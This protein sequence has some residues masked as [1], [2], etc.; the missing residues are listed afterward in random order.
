MKNFFSFLSRFK[1]KKVLCLDGG[2]VRTI[3]AIVFLMKLEAESGKKVSDVFDMFIGNSAGALNAACFAFGGF[4][5]D[6]VKRYWSENYLD[7]I[8]SENKTIHGY[9][10]STKGNVLL[11]YFGITKK[12]IK[13]IADRNPKKNNHFTPGT[14]M[15]IISENKSSKSKKKT[16]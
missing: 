14:K 9:G 2:G 16:K 15:R 13:Y 4:S 1:H 11:Q 6:K 12:Y 8:I 7:K 10:A 3:A 5:A